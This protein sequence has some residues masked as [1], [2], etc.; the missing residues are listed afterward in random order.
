MVTSWRGAQ[1]AVPLH[2]RNAPTS[3]MK[4]LGYSKGY[5]YNPAKGYA[6]GC[7]EGYLP[8][9]LKSSSFF[10]PADCEP[11][12]KLHLCRNLPAC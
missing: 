9:T 10:D 1:P 2:I 7:P 11:G 12:H 6:R 4:G 5:E 8:P 3:L